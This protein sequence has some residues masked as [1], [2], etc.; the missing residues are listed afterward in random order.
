MTAHGQTIGMLFVVHRSDTKFTQT[1]Q[2]SEHEADDL[3]TRDVVDTLM[4]LPGVV[5]VTV[6][7]EMKYTRD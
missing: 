4:N 6:K 2:Y 7:I 5:A 3:C 1:F